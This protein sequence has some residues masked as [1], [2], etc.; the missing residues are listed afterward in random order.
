MEA[1]IDFIF[2]GSKITVD[3]DRNH[4]IKRFLLLE[5]NYDKFRQHIKKQREHFTDKDHTVKAM[6]SPV[7]MYRYCWSRKKAEHQRIG[8]LKLCG[9]RKLLR[10]PWTARRSIQSVLKEINTE[11]SLEILLLK[12]KIQNWPPGLQ[13]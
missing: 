13:S 3:V 11:Y 9:W 6:A 7:I 8:A 10:A 12:L 1:A 5:G 4:E 2:L